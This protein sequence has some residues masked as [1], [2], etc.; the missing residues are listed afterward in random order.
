V[1][2][3]HNRLVARHGFESAAVEAGVW[4][5][6]LDDLLHDRPDLVEPLAKLIRE[7]A[8]ATRASTA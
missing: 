4:R 6:R 8:S 3:S 7:T 5:V 1:I 2:E